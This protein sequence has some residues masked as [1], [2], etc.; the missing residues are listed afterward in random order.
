MVTDVFVQVHLPIFH[1]VAILLTFRCVTRH[2][3]SK[4]PAE[5]QLKLLS[6]L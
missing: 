1:S 3:T 6:F 2:F 5:V 4:R